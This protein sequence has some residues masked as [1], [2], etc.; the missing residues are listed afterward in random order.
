MIRRDLLSQMCGRERVKLFLGL[1]ML[2]PS[3]GVFAQTV[4]VDQISVTQDS[5]DPRVITLKISVVNNKSLPITLSSTSFALIDPA[6]KIYPSMSPL[7]KSDVSFQMNLNPGFQVSR[8]LWFEI[9]ATVDPRRLKLTMHQSGSNNWNDYLEIPFTHPLPASAPMWHVF[10]AGQV[11]DTL[12]YEADNKHLTPPKL[13]SAPEPIWPPEGDRNL[14]NAKEREVTVVVSCIID[15]RGHLQQFELTGPPAGMG[16]DEAALRS[17]KQ[18]RFKPAV[19][20]S[21]LPVS[22]EVDIKVRFAAP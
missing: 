3:I 8:Q 12:T 15:D 1:A 2:F 22:V 18:Y 6:H 4:T 7:G 17:V 10:H 13:L 11:A 16:F 21:G 19:D 14:R 20:Q 5:L 9:P